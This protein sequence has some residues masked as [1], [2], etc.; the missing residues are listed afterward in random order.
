MT[1]KRRG[2][3][4]LFGKEFQSV[5][6]KRTRRYEDVIG[7]KNVDAVV[8]ATPITGTPRSRSLRCKTASTFISKSRY[9]MS[10]TKGMLSSLPQKKYGCVVQQGSQMRNSPVTLKA[11]KLLKSGNPW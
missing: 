3:L 5:A 10:T 11:E 8:I 2:W 1:L 7:D 9:R 6:P 4:D